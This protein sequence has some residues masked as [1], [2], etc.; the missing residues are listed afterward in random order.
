MNQIC[1]VVDVHEPPALIPARLP[2]RG[3]T[4]TSL[5]RVV[6]RPW[7]M[8]ERRQSF[9]SDGALSERHAPRWDL[10]RPGALG[11]SQA[12]DHRND[13]R[14]LRLLCLRSQGSEGE[15]ERETGI[16][17]ASTAWKAVALPLSYT[18]LERSSGHYSGPGSLWPHVPVDHSIRRLCPSMVMV[19]PAGLEPATYPL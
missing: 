11:L 10:V 7:S 5:D 16:E 1:L 15:L 14:G 6:F 18:R 4:K 3:F 17:P 19:R 2:P 12:R 13:Q 8:K 9:W